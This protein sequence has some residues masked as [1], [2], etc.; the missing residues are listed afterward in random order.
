MITQKK[1]RQ[2]YSCGMHVSGH[3]RQIKTLFSKIPQPGKER[4]I[5]KGVIVAMPGKDGDP[6]TVLDEQSFIVL[7]AQE[8][9]LTRLS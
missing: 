5:E 2:R 8:E 3:G 6:Y 1:F 9:Q 7:E 4:V